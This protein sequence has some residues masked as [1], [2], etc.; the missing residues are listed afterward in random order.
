MIVCALII[1]LGVI[2]ILNTFMNRKLMLTYNTAPQK[3][4]VGN[5]N[6][7]I[8]KKVYTSTEQ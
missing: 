2:I 5:E 6:D 3:H 4:T 8:T 1:E 7:G